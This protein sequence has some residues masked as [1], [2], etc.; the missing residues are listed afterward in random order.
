MDLVSYL[1]AKKTVDDRAL[2]ERV[3]RQ[4]FE[5]L[6]PDGHLVELGAGIGTMLERLPKT[7]RYT[8]VDA[9]AGPSPLSGSL[10]RALAL[11]ATIQ[12][13][14]TAASTFWLYQFWLY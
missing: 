2:N 10:P 6:P 14:G 5:A 13:V 4:F 1:R 8:A 3:M 12:I 7:A 11:A 9:D